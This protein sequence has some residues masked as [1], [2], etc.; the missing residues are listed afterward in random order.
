MIKPAVALLAA[1]LLSGCTQTAAPDHSAP[2]GCAQVRRAQVFYAEIKVGMNGGTMSPDDYADH[3]DALNADLSS[4][5]AL[6][7]SPL[8]SRAASAAQNAADLQ[9][10]LAPD[11]GQV[12]A[13][14]DSLTALSAACR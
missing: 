7:P 11:T 8:A 9:H 13:L 10:L 14:R 2:N 5:A 4:A 12:R 6:L 3:L 1:L